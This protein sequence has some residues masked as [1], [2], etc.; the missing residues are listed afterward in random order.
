MFSNCFL[1]VY[2]LEVQLPDLPLRS[3]LEMAL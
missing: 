2:R 3:I 1:E